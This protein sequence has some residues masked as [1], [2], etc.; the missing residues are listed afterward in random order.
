MDIMLENYQEY[1]IDISLS[2]VDVHWCGHTEQ[3]LSRPYE[4]FETCFIEKE[5]NYLLSLKA[6]IE[7]NSLM[8]RMLIERLELQSKILIVKKFK[9]SEPISNTTTG[10][11]VQRCSTS[12][13]RT[14]YT[15]ESTTKNV[16]RTTKK[17]T[18]LFVI[19]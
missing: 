2:K 6:L 4:E 9:Y 19:L 10:K 12:G 8:K 3:R 13:V 11:N 16:R 18:I 15:D 14:Y 5:K 7:K 1:L 17:L